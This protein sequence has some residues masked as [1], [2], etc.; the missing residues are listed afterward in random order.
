MTLFRTSFKRRKLL[1][2]FFFFSLL[3]FI[4]KVSRDDKNDS[5]S[6]AERRISLCFRGRRRNASY[7][8]RR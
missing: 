4:G 2:L 8:P 7:F 3:F 5:D 1:F 6:G